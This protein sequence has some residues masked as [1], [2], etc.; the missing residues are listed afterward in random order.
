MNIA[1]WIALAGVV[2][3]AL[4][5]GV[6]VALSIRK[7][8]REQAHQ[9]ADAVRQAVLDAT[10]PLIADRDYWRARADRLDDELRQ[11]RRD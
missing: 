8:A 4:A 9:Q 10:A 2:V 5:A 7:D 6:P 3:M 1:T 11:A